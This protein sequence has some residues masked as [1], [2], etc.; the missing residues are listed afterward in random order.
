MER[1]SNFVNVWFWARNDPLV[2]AE[3][4]NGAGQVNPAHYG[5]LYANFVNNNCDIGGHLG[6]NNIIINLTFCGDWAGNNYPSSCPQTCTAYVNTVPSAFS[7][8]YWQINS[9]RVYQP[10]CSA[11]STLSKRNLD[12]HRQSHRQDSDL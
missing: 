7:N 8:A 11:A 3:V 10:G 1:T 12:A 5:K 2:P 6:P 4:A 9:L